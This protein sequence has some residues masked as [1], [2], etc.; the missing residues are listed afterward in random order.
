MYY[1][2]NRFIESQHNPQEDPIMFWFNGGPGCSSVEG[3]L[4]ELGPFFIEPDG[5]KTLRQNK[6]TWNKVRCIVAVIAVK[7]LYYFHY[8]ISEPL[9]AVTLE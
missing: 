9:L 7:C 3:L 2:K 8:L 6:F 1:A 4:V 5:N